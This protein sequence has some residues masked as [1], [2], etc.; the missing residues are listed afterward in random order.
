MDPRYP[1]GRFQVDADVTPEKR[2]MWIRQL[3]AF[4]ADL[5]GAVSS[6]SPHELDTPYREG[7]WTVRQVV[8]HLADSHANAVVRIKLALTED[9]PHIKTYEEALWAELPD[10]RLDIAPSLAILQ[11]LHARLVTLLD[12]LAPE[13]FARTAQHPAWGTMTVDFLLQLYAWHGRHHLAHIELARRAAAS[14]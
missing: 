3:E 14:R 6:M 13:Q 8:H 11:G 2:R 12:A 1:I 4:P 9:R 5:T 7:G 10:V